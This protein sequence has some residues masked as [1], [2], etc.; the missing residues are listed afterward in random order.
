[1]TS[2]RLRV[3]VIDDEPALRS[4]WERLVGNQPDMELLYTLS[5]ADGLIESIKAHTPQVVLLDLRMPGRDPLDALTEA[6]RLHPA[7]K[8]VVYSGDCDRETLSKAQA[9]GASGFV[10]KLTSPLEVLEVIRRVGRGDR[11]F[12]SVA[13]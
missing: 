4:A 9:A 7:T 1:M 10:D 5:S 11:V 8:A 2:Q 12:P 13:F 3:A 6:L